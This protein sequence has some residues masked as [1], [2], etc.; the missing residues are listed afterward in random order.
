MDAIS[1]PNISYFLQGLYFIFFSYFLRKI[2][3][4]IN[5]FILCLNITKLSFV[6]I[7]IKFDFHILK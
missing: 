4:A 5:V 3:N 2:I 6:Y 1:K 7:C